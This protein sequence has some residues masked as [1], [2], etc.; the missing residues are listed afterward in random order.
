[1][2]NSVDPSG[3]PAYEE[4]CEY[5]TNDPAFL[6]KCRKRFHGYIPPLGRSRL[7][8]STAA[9]RTSQRKKDR[10]G[11]SLPSSQGLL[12]DSFVIPSRVP[13]KLTMAATPTMLLGV[14]FHHIVKDTSASSPDVCGQ[15][16]TSNTTLFAQEE[17][18]GLDSLY[19]PSSQAEWMAKY[20]M[21]LSVFDV[22]A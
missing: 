22:T 15:S 13:D 1:M 2:F 12:S 16:I 6:T 7:R 3:L 21:S 9:L 11:S 8:N 4:R 10:Q 5:R 17:E 14:P 18:M 19:D 20:K